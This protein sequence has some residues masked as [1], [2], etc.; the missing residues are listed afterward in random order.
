MKRRWKITKRDDEATGLE[1]AADS[2]RWKLTRKISDFDPA[3]EAAEVRAGGGGVSVTDA[4][5]EET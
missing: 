5:A 4:P 3:S 1:E 2:G